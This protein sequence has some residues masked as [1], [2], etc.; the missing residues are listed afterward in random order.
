MEKKGFRCFNNINCPAFAVLTSV[1]TDL[2]AFA[3]F[4]GANPLK[5]I[6]MTPP[7][8]KEPADN[9]QH[10]LLRQIPAGPALKPSKPAA[11]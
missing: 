10:L 9:C 7:P 11:I 6:Q 5:I 3:P 8:E 4:S 2:S 1:E